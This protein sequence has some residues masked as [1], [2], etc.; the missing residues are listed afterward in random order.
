MKKCLF[1]LCVLKFHCESVTC[2]H[3]VQVLEEKVMVFLLVVGGEY[4]VG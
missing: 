1:D 2:D 4:C 3:V